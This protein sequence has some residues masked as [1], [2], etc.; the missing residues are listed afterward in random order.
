[1]R[2]L[3]RKLRL[4]S[5]LTGFRSNVSGLSLISLTL[6]FDPALH[7]VLPRLPQDLVARE[8]SGWSKEELMTG[9]ALLDRLS[10]YDQRHR[11]NIRAAITDALDFRAGALRFSDPEPFRISD[12]KKLKEGIVAFS[13]VGV[14]KT[15]VGVFAIGFSII[16]LQVAA[17]VGSGLKVV[18]DYAITNIGEALVD[19]C[20]KYIRQ[21]KS[22]VSS[23][24]GHS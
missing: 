23:P 15:I 19:E 22:D 1:M 24:T 2:Q 16:L 7:N 10:E 9:E 18:G 14:R 5:N 13:Q 17:V 8:I 3:L 20:V 4:R 21:H 12:L 11:V 6:R